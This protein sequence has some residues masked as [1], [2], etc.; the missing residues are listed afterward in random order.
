MA[1]KKQCQICEREFYVSKFN[2]DEPHLYV[3]E[4]CDEE[5]HISER[6]NKHG[7]KRKHKRA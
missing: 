1:I 2:R 5:Y 4:D 7:K 3:C 6:W